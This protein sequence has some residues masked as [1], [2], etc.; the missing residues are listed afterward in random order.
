MR[1]ILILTVLFTISD[2]AT[3]HLAT[4]HLFISKNTGIAFGIPI[5]QWLTIILTI[6][7]LYVLLKFI[8]KEIG[9]KSK[10]TQILTAAILAGGT[11][12][13]VDRIQRGYVIDFIDVGFWP[14]FNLADIY[15]TVGILLLMFFYGKLKKAK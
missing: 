10:I 15:I 8:Q 7:L 14:S 1:N 9:F 6:V 2:Q 5:P 3:K 13:L 12:N 4:K 11:S